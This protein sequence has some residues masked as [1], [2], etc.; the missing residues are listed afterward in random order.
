MKTINVT[1]DD[2]EYDKLVKRKG[3]ESWHDFIL[4]AR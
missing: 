3:E 2:A 4:K 1:F